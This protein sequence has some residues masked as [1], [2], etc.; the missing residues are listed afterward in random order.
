MAITQAMTTSFKVEA[1]GATHDL[2]TDEIRMALYTSAAT[3][4][5][6]TTAYSAT[7]EVVGPGYTAGGEIMTS[8]VISADGTTAIV[9]FADVTW[10]A[11]T[12]T[13]R[14]ALVYNASKANR[15]IAVLDFGSDKI[16][17]DGDF[18]VS[19]PAAAAATA[20]LRF[21]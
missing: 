5:A 17:T 4:G 13:A 1:F 10:P 12:I 11:S 2:D 15:S 3:L 7:N 18:T 19:M 21:A 9:D 8:P 20:L 14:G 6:A 16:S